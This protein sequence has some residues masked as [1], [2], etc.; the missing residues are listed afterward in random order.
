V[1]R[2]HVKTP[3]DPASRR[4]AWPIPTPLEK[5]ALSCLEKDPELRPPSAE[6]LADRL[7]DSPSA[8]LWTTQT[9]R[10]SWEQNVIGG[11]SSSGS[12]AGLT[13]VATRTSPPRG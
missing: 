10:E 11:F 12:L 9:A 6:W 8:R 3:P 1:V 4:V 5:L 7:A 2:H 13:E